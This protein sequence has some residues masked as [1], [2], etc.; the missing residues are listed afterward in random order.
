MMSGPPRRR[1]PRWVSTLVV[2]LLAAVFLLDGS[3]RGREMV[4]STVLAPIQMGVS[5]TADQ[6]SNFVSTI[7]RVR[8]MASENADYRDRVDQLQSQLAQMHELQVENS[9]LRNLL[10]MKER[11]GQGALMPVTVI[12]RDAMPYVQAV[13]IDH[14]SNDGVRQDAIVI[15]HAGLVCHGERGNPTPVKVRSI[16]DLD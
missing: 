5:G 16:H 1:L 12:A 8:D 13:T 7:Q 9:D 14:G 6:A 4:G 10:S 11:T 15:T 3:V 2:V